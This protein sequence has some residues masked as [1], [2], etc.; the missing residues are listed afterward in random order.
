MKKKKMKKNPRRD[1]NY[2]IVSN[3]PL[4]LVEVRGGDAQSLSDRTS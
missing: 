2:E 1:N 4:R 3:K